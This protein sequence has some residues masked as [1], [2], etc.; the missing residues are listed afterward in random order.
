MLASVLSYGLNGIEGYP[1][2]VEVDCREG[3]MPSF[4]TVGLPGAAVK[5][6]RERVRSALLNSHFRFPYGPTTVN[7][8]PADVKKEG[9]RYDLP[10]AL[11]LLAASRQIPMESLCGLLVLGELSLDGGLRP[12]TGV[13]PMLIRARQDGVTRVLLPE[14][15]AGEAACLDGLA[16][17]GAKSIAQAAAFLRGE[18]EIRPTPTTAYEEQLRDAPP[19][20]DLAQVRGQYA[21][22][23]ALEIAASGGHNLLL[24]GPPGSG[25]T[26]L[27]RCLPGIL[28]RM[29][30]EEALETTRIH[31][32]SGAQS[33]LIL[34]R[35]FRAP[36]HTASAAALVGGGRTAMPGEI[37]KAHN[38]VLF[39]DELPEFPRAVLEALR[40]PME[41]GTVQVSR[42]G[43]QCEYPARFSLVCAMNPCPCGNYG[44]Q[45][46]KCR[47]TPQMIERYLSR[48]SGPLLDR[49]DLVVEMDFV[50][51]EE[52][53]K[54]RAPGESSETVRLRV[55]RARKLARER[56]RGS[57]IYANA[58]LSGA[59]IETYCPLDDEARRFL[60]TAM[61]KLQLS[62]RAATRVLKLSRTLADMEQA[63]RI[64]SS[65]IAEALSYRG[66]GE[67][68]WKS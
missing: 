18:E 35:P 62:M 63:E 10:I 67:K 17:Y 46:K 58:Q 48:V 68:Y 53:L 65:H 47:C 29:S 2:Q 8:A 44:S 7:L 45:V 11:G 25:K 21:A 41:D 38:G 24:I 43:A 28:P 57:G 40:Q 39:L 26:M 66:A 60:Q 42:V 54:T 1:M 31:S 34:Q 6:S 51:A 9:P 27:A 32:V 33:G 59:Q 19:Q 15:N 50:P 13:L 23:R 16:V 3:G 64:S 12:I 49:I 14:Q 22:K 20:M 61:A 56:Y 52:A 36:H 5:E 55:E 37:S 4:E 30:F